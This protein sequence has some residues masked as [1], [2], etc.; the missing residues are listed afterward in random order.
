MNANRGM[1]LVAVAVWVAALVLIFSPS[2][3]AAPRPA[4]V[5][6]HASHTGTARQA[7]R[8]VK[9]SHMAGHCGNGTFTVCYVTT[10]R[11][12]A[13]RTIDAHSWVVRGRWQEA[14]FLGPVYS[15]VAIFLSSPHLGADGKQMVGYW[16]GTERCHKIR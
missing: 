5:V 10:M 16:Q 8:R 1:W 4:P 9:R 12:R 14:R 6:A 11:A 3:S 2:I 15:C 13:T 7:E